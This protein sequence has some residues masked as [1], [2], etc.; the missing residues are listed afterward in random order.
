MGCEMQH[1]VVAVEGAS[2]TNGQEQSSKFLSVTKVMAA[3]HAILCLAAATLEK[4]SM[5]HLV[6]ERAKDVHSGGLGQSHGQ[7]DGNP[8]PVSVALGGRG[9][10]AI[11]QMGRPSQVN[12]ALQNG[13]KQLPVQLVEY[14]EGKLPRRVHA[15]LARSQ[16]GNFAAPIVFDRLVCSAECLLCREMQIR[17]GGLSVCVF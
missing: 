16:T 2:M 13:A 5:D 11:R 9:I 17:A 3:T 7:A 15:A 12:I 1:G 4:V 6:H 10:D 14:H 8:R